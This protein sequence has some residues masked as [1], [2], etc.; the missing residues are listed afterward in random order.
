MTG[1]VSVVTLLRVPA[2]NRPKVGSQNRQPKMSISG[3]SGKEHL[4]LSL[5][6]SRTAVI[7]DR[8]RRN[9]FSLIC[10]EKGGLWVEDE[11]KIARACNCQHIQSY[12][13]PSIQNSSSSNSNPNS[14][15]KTVCIL[16]Y[17][18]TRW[19]F[20]LVLLTFRYLIQKMCIIFIWKINRW[21]VF[22]FSWTNLTFQSL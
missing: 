11:Y 12:G 16:Y 2:R 1:W 19:Y 21:I 14:N 5:S 6:L 17:Y 3:K 20:F 8:H 9:F 15:M 13:S 4:S 18:Y 10:V 22:Y 7:A